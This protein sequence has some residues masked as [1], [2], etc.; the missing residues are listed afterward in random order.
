M[1][2]FKESLDTAMFTT[3]YVIAKSFPILYVYHFH[4]SSW[5][6]SG[7][8]DNLKDEDYTVVSLGEILSIDAS[9]LE[10]AEMP[11]GFE[12]VRSA[13]KDKWKIISGN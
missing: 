4:D 13:A 2:R 9:I 5:Q 1:N 6:F 3:K 10:L 8:E 7:K 11:E 12:A